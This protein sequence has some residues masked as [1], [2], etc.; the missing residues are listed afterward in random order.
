M[1]ALE[2]RGSDR[3]YFKGKY[4]DLYILNLSIKIICDFRFVRNILYN[5][6]SI[7]KFYNYNI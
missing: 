6:I 3:L 7:F 5:S 1:K 4:V 2:Q